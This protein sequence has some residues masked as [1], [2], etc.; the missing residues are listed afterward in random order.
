VARSA[1]TLRATLTPDD[2]AIGRASAAVI[3]LD[4]MIEAM[5]RDGTKM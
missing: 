2:V 3:R 4:A 5:R 1:A